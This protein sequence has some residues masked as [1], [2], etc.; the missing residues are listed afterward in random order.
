MGIYVGHVRPSVVGADK[1]K[2][3]LAKCAYPG[4]G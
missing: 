1:G 3:G 4:S 2:A